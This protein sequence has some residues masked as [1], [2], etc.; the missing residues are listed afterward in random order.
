MVLLSAIYITEYAGITREFCERHGLRFKAMQE[1]RKLRRQLANE[2]SNFA[3]VT[4]DPKTQPP[5][6]EEAYL[7]R[8]ILLAGLPD[9]VARR[10]QLD[11]LENV[12]NETKKK[13]KYAYFT[14]TMEQPVFL[15]NLS[16]LKNHTPP[17]WVVFQDS[18]EVQ[19]KIYM[20]G[21]TAIDP[22][23]LPEFCPVDCNL[24]K[25][26]TNREPFYQ[27]GAVMILRTGTFGE[28]S[29]TLP[30]IKSEHPSVTERTKFF[31]K[32]LLEGKVFESLQKFQPDLLSPPIAMIRSW[33]NLHSKRT[34]PLFETLLSAQVDSKDKMC[35]KLRQEPDFLRTEFLLWLDEE[36]HNQVKEIW[37]ELLE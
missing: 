2:L 8:Q 11:E 4:L 30:L 31:A 16:I 21:V 29:W 15:H 22:V 19:G 26:L 23:W 9:H 27:D 10:V 34:K 20:R 3:H 1:I 37:T 24:S 33:A 36:H 7:L 13:F 17:E 6:D 12:T 28:R 5:T 14:R 18:Y 25:P 32:F 35:D